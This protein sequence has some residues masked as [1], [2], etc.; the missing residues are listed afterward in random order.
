MILIGESSRRELKQLSVEELRYI[1]EKLEAQ[2]L[3]VLER[4]QERESLGELLELSKTRIEL[5]SEKGSLSKKRKQL[6]TW[7]LAGPIPA[8]VT[9]LAVP[10]ALG[11]SATVGTIIVS[12]VGALSIA[13]TLKIKSK[14]ESL[15]A[16]EKDNCLQISLLAEHLK[17][18]LPNHVEN[19]GR[20][21][22]AYV[23]ERLRSLDCAPNESTQ[24]GNDSW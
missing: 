15:A 6:A 10:F 3:A 8:T 22:S 12:T 7:V 11:A 9:S 4:E 13:A 24:R 14:F 20:T 23:Q 5:E 18:Q 19:S 2:D 16:K 21:Q 1:A 17:T